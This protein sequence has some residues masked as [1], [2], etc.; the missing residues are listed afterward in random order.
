MLLLWLFPLVVPIVL[1]LQ[2]ICRNEVADVHNTED[3]QAPQNDE[4]VLFII[5]YF[6]FKVIH[7]W[8][9]CGLNANKLASQTENTIGAYD[10]CAS[11]HSNMVDR[12]DNNSQFIKIH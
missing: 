2:S 11:I 10:Y 12:D 8:P 9:I 5:I 6:H 7:L 1:L 3:L 4:N